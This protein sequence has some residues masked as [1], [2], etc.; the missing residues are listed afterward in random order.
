M[1][2]MKQARDINFTDVRDS[3]KRLAVRMEL[4]LRKHDKKRGKAG[5]IPKYEDDL[6]DTHDHLLNRLDQEVVE[7]HTAVR[8]QI[9]TGEGLGRVSDECADVANFA[10]MIHEVFGIPRRKK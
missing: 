8:C 6:E 10:M 3:I 9:V 7:L 5:W 4:K 2:D 1:S